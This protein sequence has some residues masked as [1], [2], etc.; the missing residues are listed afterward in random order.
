MDLIVDLPKL[1]ALSSLISL[2]VLLLLY[3]LHLIDFVYIAKPPRA[4][5]IPKVA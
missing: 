1:V 2:F 4:V 3:K 5:L